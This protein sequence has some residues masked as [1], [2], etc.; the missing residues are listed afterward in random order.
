MV[1]YL[2]APAEAAMTVRMSVTPLSPIAGQAAAVSVQT[3]APFTQKCVDD[4]AADHRPWS[5]WYTS[6]GTLRLLA[7]ATREGAAPIEIPLVRRASDLTRWDG[8]VLFPT[9]GAW[10]LRMSSPSWS[11][12]GAESEACAGARRSVVVINRLPGTTTIGPTEPTDV[13]GAA[14]VSALAA[15]I[16]IVVARWRRPKQYR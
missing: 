9:A 8:A 6:D 15:G 12:A 14:Y 5:D 13:A 11:Q 10:T 4:P 16:L 3:L 1:F 2:V 7:Q